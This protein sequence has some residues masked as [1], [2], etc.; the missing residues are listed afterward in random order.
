MRNVSRTTLSLIALALALAAIASPALA[1]NTRTGTHVARA[2]GNPANGKKLFASSG[3]GACHTL[4]AA[5]AKGS[6]GPNLDKVKPALAKTV[7]QITSGGEAMP[8]FKSRLKASQIK[9]VAAFVFKST[10]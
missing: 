3:C 4:K 8:S 9:D 1:R 6:V 2:A 7:K 10:H 5:G